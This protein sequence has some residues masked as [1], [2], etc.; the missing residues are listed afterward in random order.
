MGGKPIKAGLMGDA[1]VQKKNEKMSMGENKKCTGER[2]LHYLRCFSM[3]K[4]HFEVIIR[5]L[6]RGYF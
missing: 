3:S 2:Q 6:K 5:D 1:K 4:I